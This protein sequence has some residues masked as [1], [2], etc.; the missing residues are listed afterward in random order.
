MMPNWLASGHTTIEL[1]E[2]VTLLELLLVSPEEALDVDDA[3]TVALVVDERPLPLVLVA[4]DDVE[5]PVP[6]VLVPGLHAKHRSWQM[7]PVVA[8]GDDGPVE[9]VEDVPPEPPAPTAAS[10]AL[11]AGVATEMAGSATSAACAKRVT[12]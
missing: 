1:P 11:H 9:R 8:E 7:K 4:L 10:F 5:P 3:E 12:R 2:L 6:D